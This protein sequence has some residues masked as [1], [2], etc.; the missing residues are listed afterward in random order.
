MRFWQPEEVTAAVQVW[1]K[2]RRPDSVTS[3][4]DCNTEFLDA[5][6]GPLLFLIPHQDDEILGCG[7]L[8]ALLPDKSRLHFAFAT[9]GASFPQPLIPQQGQYDPGLSAIREQESRNALGGLGVPQENIR[10]LG[11]P[12][13]GLRRSLPALRSDIVSL[14]HAVRPRVVFAPFRYDRHP[15]HLAL[16]E[17]TAQALRECA[18]GI[19]LCEYIVYF[20]WP[21]L[22]NVDIRSNMCPGQLV[23]VD[24]TPVLSQ[25]RGALDC[26]VSQFTRF[27]PWQER[28]GVH[29]SMVEEGYSST[30]EVFI[31]GQPSRPL[32]VRKR[33]LYWLA[34]LLQRYVEWPLTWQK[35]VWQTRFSYWRRPA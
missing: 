14:I 2:I 4:P 24:I 17:A 1:D 7:G 33:A 8:I 6:G 5:L 20:R 11:Y 27:Y 16:Y 12:D 31:M 15:D 13:A 10:F 30:S 35:K 29:R 18:G 23:T 9:D 25:K 19:R 32:F 34:H 3:S 22:G 21:L 28:P 26:F